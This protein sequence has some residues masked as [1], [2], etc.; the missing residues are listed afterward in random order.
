MKALILIAHGSRKA[1]SNTEFSSM[2]SLLRL[3]LKNTFE[4]VEA[5]FLEFC[6]PS[7][8]A[9]LEMMIQKG[10]T[11]I[12]IY[13]FFLNSGKHVTVDIPM[14]IE[15]IQVMYPEVSLRLLPHFGSS[16]HI[17]STIIS[18]LEDL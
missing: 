3:K 7:I 1:A 2:V 4:H 13:P 5:S 10:I 14:K 16:E 11:E 15:T 17:I 6:E 18:D 12:L 8:E 9:S